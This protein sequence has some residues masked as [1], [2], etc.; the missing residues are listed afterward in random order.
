MSYSFDGTN[1]RLTGQ[2]TSTYPAPITM[3]LMVKVAA[4]P[5]SV[6]GLFNLGINSGSDPDSYSIRTSGVDDTWVARSVN[7]AGTTSAASVVFGIDGVWA[8]IVA[9]FT[10]STLRDIYVQAY[11]NTATDVLN[12]AVASGSGYFIHIGELLG[13]VS[14]FTGNIAEVAVWDKALTQAEIEAYM[15]FNPSSGIAAS[16]L[17]GYWPLSASNAT[18]SNDGLDA[19]GDLTVTG[20]TFDADHPTMVGGGSAARKRRTTLMGV[21]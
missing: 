15:A 6:R 12:R 5:V 16:N 21:G 10:S 17:I 14:D 4:H 1:D 13:S 20:A 2:F 7:T 8:G 3:A 19:G 18:Q 11:A 9:R